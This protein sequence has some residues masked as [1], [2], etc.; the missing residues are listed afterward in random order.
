MIC[1]LREHIWR[2]VPC[3][4]V[5]VHCSCSYVDKCIKCGKV[6]VWEARHVNA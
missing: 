4:C 5:D 1:W 6:R 3:D 2:R